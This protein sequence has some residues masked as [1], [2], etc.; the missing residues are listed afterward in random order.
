GVGTVTPALIGRWGHVSQYR[1]GAPKRASAHSTVMAP[2][3]ES[4][5]PEANNN[6]DAAK[7]TTNSVVENGHQPYAEKAKMPLDSVSEAPTPPTQG[8]LPAMS[9]RMP[10]M[11]VTAVT[12]VCGDPHSTTSNGSIRQPISEPKSSMEMPSKQSST[13]VVLQPVTELSGSKW[14]VPS[15]REEPLSS[16]VNAAN[17]NKSVAAAEICARKCEHSAE[18]PMNEQNALSTGEI[19]FLSSYKIIVLGSASSS[20]T[21]ILSA[22][23]VGLCSLNDLIQIRSV[24]IVNYSLPRINGLL[25]GRWS[26]GAHDACV[27]MRR[28]CCAQQRKCERSRRSGGCAAALQRGISDA[29]VLAAGADMRPVLRAAAAL[30]CAALECGCAA[31]SSPESGEVETDYESEGSLNFESPGFQESVDSLIEAVNQSLG[32][33]DELASSSDHNVTFKR[34]KRTHRV[35]AS[36]PEFK[37]LIRRNREHP[38]KRFSGLR[39]L[40]AS[41]DRYFDVTPKSHSPPPALS[42]QPEKKRELMRSQTLPRSSG[43]QVRKA[44]FEKFEQDSSNDTDNDQDRCSVAVWSLESC[45]TDRSPATND[46]EVP[47]NQGKHRVTK[48]RAALSNPMFTLVTIVKDG[49]QGKHRVTKRGPAL[50]YPMFTLVTSE[51]IAESA[52]HTPIQRCQRDLNDQKMAPQAIP[53]RPAIS[54]QG[55]DRCE[56]L[57]SQ[58]VDT[59]PVCLKE[60]KMESSRDSDFPLRSKGE[61]KVKLK[62]SQSFGVASASSIKQIL[63]EWCR[64]KTIGYKNIDLQNFS[65]SWS[66]GMAFCALVHSFFP[67]DFDYDALVPSN[68]R[69]NFEQAFSTAE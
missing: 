31:L 58:D 57:R 54:Q 60:L 56:K 22:G 69:H 25:N 7:P 17:S 1:T 33:E 51:D 30:R 14:L 64:S 5:V 41:T 66:D 45:H 16:L 42:R 18:Y 35:F 34:A 4:V 67:E 61:S 20:V 19:I 48:R 10:H 2:A 46:P 53:T 24:C 28:R 23:N 63:L 11:P 36:H 32:I 43:T 49:N 39:A 29:I 15:T 40:K 12:K 47:G 52:S 26:I 3:R 8:H 59:G 44:F 38:D 6:V 68:H 13:Q 55:A 50:S 9:V 62:R 65:S 27:G 21:R 37:D